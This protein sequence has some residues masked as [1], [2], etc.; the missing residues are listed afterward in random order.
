VNNNMFSDYAGGGIKAA[1]FFGTVK[2]AVNRNERMDDNYQHLRYLSRRRFYGG[3]CIFNH[4][5][6]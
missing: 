1:Y 2:G 4:N 5:N 3:V 6:C